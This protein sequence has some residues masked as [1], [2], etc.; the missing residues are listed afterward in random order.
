MAQEEQQHPPTEQELPN[1]ESPEPKNV[2]LKKAF[3]KEDLANLTSGAKEKFDKTLAGMKG[4]AH[5]MTHP[6]NKQAKE[7]AKAKTAEQKTEIGQKQQSIRETARIQLMEQ[8]AVADGVDPATVRG[9]VPGPATGLVP[10]Q[11]AQLVHGD[12]ADSDMQ[13]EA[14]PGQGA[15]LD[16]EENT[17][18]AMEGAEDDTEPASGEPTNETQMGE[19]DEDKMAE[20]TSDNSSRGRSRALNQIPPDSQDYQSG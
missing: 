18:S 13:E 15:E 5:M 17:D 9:L 8:K 16:K 7:E 3:A 4:A 11:G 12:N 10:G 14:T 2:D 19:R 6:F 1:E 20:E